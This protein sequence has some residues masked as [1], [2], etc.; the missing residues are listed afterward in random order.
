MRAACVVLLRQR[1]PGVWSQRSDFSDNREEAALPVW[2]RAQNPYHRPAHLL[3]IRYNYDKLTRSWK[4]PQALW[5]I[6]VFIY[7][8]QKI[9]GNFLRIMCRNAVRDGLSRRC[10]FRNTGPV[11]GVQCTD[12]STICPFF[13]SISFARTLHDRFLVQYNTTLGMELS[14]EECQ[15]EEDTLK[16]SIPH[17]YM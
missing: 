5:L 11:H 17:G 9:E 7:S 6:S 13:P 14:V 15:A 4:R 10:F 8:A 1:C 2:F 12:L 16:G 3:A